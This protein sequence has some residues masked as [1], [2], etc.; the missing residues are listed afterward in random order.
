MITANELKTKGI[1][2]IESSLKDQSEVAI[3]VRGKVRYVAMTV[4]QFDQLR[5]AELEVAYSQSLEE[6]KKGQFSVSL[7]EHFKEIDKAA[8]NA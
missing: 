4:E 1:K 2:A 8:G 5:L 6:I 7:E 3:S